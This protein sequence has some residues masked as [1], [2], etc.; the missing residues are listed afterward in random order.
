MKEFGEEGARLKFTLVHSGKTPT[1]CKIWISGQDWSGEVWKSRLDDSVGIQTRDVIIYGEERWIVGQ[2]GSCI[3]I[4]C[5]DKGHGRT[6]WRAEPIDEALAGS[7][8]DQVYR[9][10]Y[11]KLFMYPPWN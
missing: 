9:V 2:R 10:R 6:R 7:R 8:T 3:E 11:K 5:F 1:D 4:L